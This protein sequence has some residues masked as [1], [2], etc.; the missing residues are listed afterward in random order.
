[1]TDMALEVRGLRK[2]FHLAKGGA[3]GGQTLVAVDDISF[4]VPAGGALALVGESGSG[5]TTVARMVCGL[6]QPTSGTVHVDGV[7]RTP[8]RKRAERLALSRQVQMVFQDPY[9]SL[10]RRQTV[11]SCLDEVLRLHHGGDS[12]TRAVR[13]DQLLQQVGL[14]SRHAEL[15]PRS[16]SGGQRQRVGI[17]RALA[18]EP[19][20]LILD[21]SVAALDVSIQAQILNLLN[22]LRA[23]I[24]IAY[25]FVTHDLAVAHYVC[26]TA[27][28]MRNGRAVEGGPAS[29]TLTRPQ[30]PYTRRLLD[31]VP[32]VGW[33]PRRRGPEPVE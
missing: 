28:V 9:S 4:S 8:P 7:E 31:A 17:A 30:E 22:A 19:A 11:H 6:E 15:R 5:K 21:E 26:D 23:D 14:D 13:V 24:G 18:V 33:V 3:S 27:L 10:D 12:R 20:V 25:L 16:L 32:R 2:E 29:E 1:M